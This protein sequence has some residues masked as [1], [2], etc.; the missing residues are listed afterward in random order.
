MTEDST[1]PDSDSRAS[2][3]E[4]GTGSDL[5]DV[6]A[7]GRGLPS[8]VADSVRSDVCE[9]M[10]ALESIRSGANTP[11]D[12]ET[13]T[14]GCIDAYT[15]IESELERLVALLREF[16]RELREYRP[17]RCDNCGTV[18]GDEWQARDSEAKEVGEH[19]AD[20]PECGENPLP[21]VA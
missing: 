17:P 5:R 6:A 4:T 13:Y 2:D 10:A 16:D 15:E 18:L 14:N 12:M 3:G 8:E 1:T 21:P 11:S 9:R 7:S 20:C 19:P